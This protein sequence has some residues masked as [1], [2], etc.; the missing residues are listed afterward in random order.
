MSIVEPGN[1]PIQDLAADQPAA[2]YPTYK[3]KR[4]GTETSVLPADN[5]HQPV[6]G[7]AWVREIH[8]LSGLNEHAVRTLLEHGITVEEWV[9]AGNYVYVEP[10]VEWLGD[11]CGCTDNRCIGFHHLDED[12]CG[13]LPV[14]IEEYRTNGKLW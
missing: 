6:C 12:S 4:C 10:G 13:C 1:G 5:H 11:R 3:C 8:A 9:A 2:G 14:L 7:G